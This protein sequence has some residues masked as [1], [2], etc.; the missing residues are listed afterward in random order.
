MNYHICHQK[1]TNKHQFS[2]VIWNGKCDVWVVVV[3]VPDGCKLCCDSVNNNT[4]LQSPGYRVQGFSY[5]LILVHL[6]CQMSFYTKQSEHLIF[7]IA[8]CF[9][10]SSSHCIYIN[11][12]CVS[13]CGWCKPGVGCIDAHSSWWRDHWPMGAVARVRDSCCSSSVHNT[14]HT[15]SPSLVTRTQLELELELGLGLVLELGGSLIVEVVQ[16]QRRPLLGPS[17]G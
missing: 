15:A 1:V 3:A 14:A 5:C 9:L 17:L 6:P 4:T 8:L 16:S 7:F 11:I 13:G 10:L 12:V 2:C